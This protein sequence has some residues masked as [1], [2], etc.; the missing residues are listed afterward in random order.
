VAETFDPQARVFPHGFLHDVSLVDATSVP[1]DVIAGVA[2]PIPTEWLSQPGWS[3]I[4]YTSQALFLLDSPN[5]RAKS[6]GILGSQCQMVGQAIF[7]L[8]E[9]SEKKTRFRFPFAHK[10][11]GSDRNL[12]TWTCLVSR[13]LLYRIDAALNAPGA[14]SGTAVCIHENIGDGVPRAKVA[15][16]SSWAQPVSDPTRFDMDDRKLYSRLEEGR[17]AFYGAFQAPSK[18]RDEYCIV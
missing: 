10:T 2:S 15:G 17:V 6:I 18:L 3:N 9:R 5:V 8:R 1:M 13:S 7:K 11:S 16:F 14:Q 4:K 12:E